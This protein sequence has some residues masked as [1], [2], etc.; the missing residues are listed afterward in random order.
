MSFKHNAEKKGRGEVV[1]TSPK[2]QFSGDICNALLGFVIMFQCYYYF[3]S[4]VSFSK[5]PESFRNLT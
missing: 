3:S 1:D 2:V 4:G 5:I